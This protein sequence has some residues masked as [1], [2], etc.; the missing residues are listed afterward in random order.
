[1]ERPRLADH[2]QIIPN[3][4]GWMI[5]TGSEEVFWPFVHP[6]SGGDALL[7]LMD[8]T[9][10]FNSIV[11]LS[12][13]DPAEL[14]RFVERLSQHGLLHEGANHADPND[15]CCAY[16]GIATPAQL[17]SLPRISPVLLAGL[18]ELG[19]AV[20]RE[21]LGVQN[22]VVYLFDPVPVQH[23]D[24]KY[25]YLSTELGQDKTEVVRNRLGSEA[26]EMVRCIPTKEP[27]ADT[28]EMA[29]R[30]T[31]RD[32]RVAI[33]CSERPSYLP[34]VLAGI[35]RPL[36]IPV[37]PASITSSGGTIGPIV[38]PDASGSSGGC[39]LCASLYQ[40]RRDPF[41]AA[42]YRHLQDRFPL[43][44]S[45][46][47]S[48]LPL[49]RSVLSQFVLLA[50]GQAL[51]ADHRLH[52]KGSRLVALGREGWTGEVKLIPKHYACQQCFRATDKNMGQ[53]LSEKKHFWEQYYENAVAEPMD[54]PSL[55]NRLK[56]LAGQE[57]GIF[58]SV[59]GDSP[60]ERQ[61][62]YRFFSSR[63]VDPK[64]SVIANAHC[65]VARRK[66][67]RG[68]QLLSSFTTGLDFHDDRAAKALSLMESLE[69]L[70]TLEYCDPTW[71]VSKRY[72][73]VRDRAL[74]P[75]LFPLYS[76]RQYKDPEFGLRRFDPEEAIQWIW[77]IRVSDSEPIL[78]PF[79]LIYG[80]RPRPLYRNNSNGSAAHSSLHHAILNGIYET[81]ERDSLMVTWFNEM[82]L[83]LVELAE[84]DFDPFAVRKQLEQLSFE[85]IHVDLTTDLQIPVILGILRD[86]LNPDVFLL[87]MASSLDSQ[88]LLRKLYKE[89][90]QFSHPYS[91]DRTYYQS[92]ISHASSPERVLTFRDHLSFYQHRE[93]IPKASFLT[94]SS[95]RKPFGAGPIC[96]QPESVKQ[97]LER[98][99]RQLQSRG[100]ETIAVDCTAPFLKNLDLYAVKV[101]IPGLQPLHAGHKY[102]PLGGARLRQV[103]R[104][105]GLAS[106]EKTFE[107]LNPWPHPFW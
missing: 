16:F 29:L 12:G 27:T 68:T 33:C 22:V 58:A 31:I 87:S 52:S 84:T 88:Q 4:S 43:P 10:D 51:D 6:S 85:L 95:S 105:M 19:L 18:G 41:S 47:Y 7:D 100:Y 96:S 59:S 50:L 86:R 2:A 60:E 106:R 45:R 56:P 40:A 76:E 28:V 20:L 14:R 38:W 39:L 54:L 82:S 74:D 94:A 5:R 79:E 63:G 64:S 104:Q 46:R 25:F 66:F 92:E 78:V 72:S 57:Y 93:K 23:G 11:E 9:R 80:S 91:V 67:V 98:I 102:A 30:N 53:L 103:A 70:F 107:E 55:W 42:L 101:L 3:A 44:A 15:D 17:L 75:R 1:M 61:S 34:E 97:E 26:R 32:V 8:G 35:C 21:L 37:I 69:R 49:L 62:V 99:V 83:P 65:A 36:G 81:V 48:P 71:I 73:E 24:R 90:V 77:G 13:T 89:L